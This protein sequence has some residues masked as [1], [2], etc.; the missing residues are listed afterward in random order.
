MIDK[1]EIIKHFKLYSTG[2]FLGDEAIINNRKKSLVERYYIFSYYLEINDF[3]IL[4]NTGFSERVKPSTDLKTLKLFHR[5]D[6]KVFETLPSQLMKDHI[7]PDQI[8]Y[9]IITNFAS[10]H[11]GYLNAFKNATIITSHEAYH[12]FI[13]QQVSNNSLQLSFHVMPDDFKDRIEFIEN[14]SKVD[15]SVLGKGF[16]IFNN[17]SLISYYLPGAMPGQFGL[18]MKFQDLNIFMCSDAAWCRSNLDKN[19]LPTKRLL[20]QSY[21]GERFIETHMKLIDFKHSSNKKLFILPSH[22]K[23]MDDF[24]E[25][26]KLLDALN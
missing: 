24:E 10:H 6:Y 19:E 13:T 7:H 14:F 25:V 23:K 16:K 20:K 9:C 12:D 4:I 15:D 21:N 26:L 2:S 22:C 18:M 11:I 8:D 3:K 17:D 1:H 5:Q